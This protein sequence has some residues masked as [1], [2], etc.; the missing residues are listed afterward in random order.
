ML[1]QTK[2]KNTHADTRFHLLAVLIQKVTTPTTVLF[3]LSSVQGNHCH[4][5]S[6]ILCF[7]LC[8]LSKVRKSSSIHLYEATEMEINFW[9]VIII[10]CHLIWSRN[11]SYKI[12][13]HILKRTT[14]FQ[15]IQLR[16]IM[17]SDMSPKSRFPLHKVRNPL[18]EKYLLPLFCTFARYLLGISY[19]KRCHNI[20]NLRAGECSWLPIS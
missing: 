20:G 14:T 3:N 18:N 10:R 12:V 7:C 6:M 15:R 19:I 1:Q 5:F 16:K 11:S 9:S 8:L 17:I 4:I 2:P 13:E